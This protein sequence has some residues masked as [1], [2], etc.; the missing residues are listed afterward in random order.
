MSRGRAFAR[1]ATC[2]AVASPRWPRRCAAAVPC[3]YTRRSVFWTT[4]SGCS[5][6]ARLDGAHLGDREVLLEDDGHEV[7]VRAVALDAALQVVERAAEE[8]GDEAKGGVEVLRLAAVQEEREGGLVLGEDDAVAVEDEAPRRRHGHAAQ[9]VVLGLALVRL[10]PEDL[11]DPVHAGEEADENPRAP[12]DDV[13]A[14]ENGAAVFAGA[15]RHQSQPHAPA[16]LAPLFPGHARRRVEQAAEHSRRQS[17][18]GERPGRGRKKIARE[19]PDQKRERRRLHENGA[20]E[21]AADG[22]GLLD[23]RARAHRGEEVP[24]QDLR[25]RVEPE[26]PAGREETVLEKAGGKTGQHRRHGGSAARHVRDDE[27]EE[28]RRGRHVERAERERREDREGEPDRDAERL[29]AARLTLSGVPP[30]RGPT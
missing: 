6:D 3:V 8:L 13:D 17:A 30:R 15:G 23:D 20:R 9:A 18:R 7:V 16:R 5:S 10:A 24:D 19:H 4:S 27:K 12:R 11:M 28:V 25:E 2:S 21:E 26:Q 22:H 29:H 14:R 1:A